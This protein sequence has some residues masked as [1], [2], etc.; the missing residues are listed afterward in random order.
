MQVVERR[1]TEVHFS[2]DELGHFLRCY[3]QAFQICCVCDNIFAT[4]IWTRR[5]FRRDSL[6]WQYSTSAAVL[7]RLLVFSSCGMSTMT[8]SKGGLSKQ[9]AQ[10][11]GGSLESGVHRGKLYIMKT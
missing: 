1:S 5:G 7:E 11:H 4:S 2:I 6:A 3:Q 9:V 10:K 8:G